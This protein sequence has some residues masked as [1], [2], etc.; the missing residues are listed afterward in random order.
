MELDI[1][2]KYSS[3]AH[4]NR[5]EIEYGDM[6]YIIVNF[7]SKVIDDNGN[8]REFSLDEN[9]LQLIEN[10]IWEYENLDEYDYWPDKS[11][12]HPPMAIKW[13][14]SWWDSEEKYHHKSGVTKDLIGLDELINDLKALN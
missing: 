4:I 6:N 7:D 5:V 3:K 1:E 9:K 13:R 10:R 8:L 14:L 11:K 2:K 12:D